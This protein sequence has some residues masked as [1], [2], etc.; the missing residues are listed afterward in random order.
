MSGLLLKKGRVKTMLSKNSRCFAQTGAVLGCVL[1]LMHTLLQGESLTFDHDAS[2]AVVVMREHIPIWSWGRMINIRGNHTKT[3]V[4]SSFNEQ[5]SLETSI[6]FALPDTDSITISRFAAHPHGALVVSGWS[7]DRTGRLAAF[8][9]TLSPSSPARVVRTNP[10]FPSDIAVA[11]DG[12]VWTA[13][14]VLIDGKEIKTDYDVLRQYA[15]DG[16]MLRSAVP[17]SSISK[18]EIADGGRMAASVGR[19]GWYTGPLKG[20]DSEYIEIRLDGTIL[21]TP[22]CPLGSKKMINGFA[23]TNSGVFVSA[24]DQTVGSTTVYALRNGKWLATEPPAAQKQRPGFLYGGDGDQLVAQGGD[25]NTVRF[26]R[27]EK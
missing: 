4:I 11:Y 14:E 18:D 1:L 22:G 24:E 3:P 8:F 13:G 26:L 10:Y 21:R 15:A 25:F 20:V 9:A 12:T 19:V 23:L 7:A 2:M 6:A 17:R 5:G 16:T 27:P